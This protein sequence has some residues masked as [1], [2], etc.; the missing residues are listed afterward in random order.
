[1]AEHSMYSNMGPGNQAPQHVHQ[2]VE[3]WAELSLEYD[4]HFLAQ[5]D[6]DLQAALQFDDLLHRSPD[7]QVDA[8]VP[9]Q[10]GST[11]QQ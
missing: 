7:L 4:A 9:M 5:E 3:G 8:D 11:E 1:M 2:P 10:D 6:V